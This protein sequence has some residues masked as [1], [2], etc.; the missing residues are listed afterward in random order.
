M[1]VP[2]CL[3]TSNSVRPLLSKNAL[4]VAERSS[5]ADASPVSGED[6]KRAEK[7]ARESFVLGGED[8][9]TALAESSPR[10]A[11]LDAALRE[12]DA[13]HSEPSLEGRGGVSPGA[14]GR[15]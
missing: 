4:F 15:G 5:V 3:L 10:R 13:G 9:A 7:F 1:G 8:A 2:R 6:L 11:A 12:I 14:R